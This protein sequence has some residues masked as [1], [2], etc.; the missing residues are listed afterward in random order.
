VI[1]AVCS[2][3]PALIMDVEIP[4]NSQAQVHVNKLNL[5]NPT[6]TTTGSSS[7]NGNVIWQDGKVVNFGTSVNSVEENLREN[8]VVVSVGA[9]KYS[10]VVQSV[11]GNGKLVCAVASDNE[12]MTLLCPEGSKIS[13]VAFA[14]YGSPVV[15][16]SDTS[17]CSLDFSHGTHHTGSS[18]A[19]IENNCLAKSEC[20]LHVQ[21]NLFAVNDG[22]TARRKLAVSVYCS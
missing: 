4:G 6:I 3:A 11:Q 10:F 12:D 13:S 17:S 1:K 19:I 22:E 16:A 20:T 5:I 2:G 8:S 15:S 9:G 18:G 21:P 7:P 14:S